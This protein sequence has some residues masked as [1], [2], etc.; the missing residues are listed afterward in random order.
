MLPVRVSAPAPHPLPAR[1]RSV[2]TAASDEAPRSTT[3]IAFSSRLCSVS[4]RRHESTTNVVALHV[5]SSS[6]M[7]P[8]FADPEGISSLHTNGDSRNPVL[9]N[10]LVRRGALGRPVSSRMRPIASVRPVVQPECRPETR[11]SHRSS[12]GLMSTSCRHDSPVRRPIIF[13]IAT[14]AGSGPGGPPPAPVASRVVGADRGTQPT[15]EDPR[16]RGCR[17][18]TS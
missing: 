7:V 13:R 12:V 11:W 15:D 10:A 16:L 1:C 14:C 3:P 6:P 5:E 18:A 17:P 2:G 8:P 4:N 9:D